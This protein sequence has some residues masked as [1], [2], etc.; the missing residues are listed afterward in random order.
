MWFGNIV[1]LGAILVSIPMAVVTFEALLAVVRGTSKQCD[2]GLD[3]FPSSVVLVPAHNEEEVIGRTL[4]SIAVDLP[5]NCRVLCVAHNCSD[6]T[7]EI[8]RR[9]GAEAIEVRDAGTG[10]KPDA[11][12]AGLSWLD[13]NPP[14]VVVIVDADCTVGQGTIRILATQASVLNRPVMGAYFF[15]SDAS[16]GI[17]TLSELAVMLKNF[18]RPLGLSIVG[19]PCLLNG[20]GSAYPF[21]LIRNAPHGEQSIAEDYQ[22]SVDL[23]RMGYPTTFVP[24]ARIDGQLPKQENTALRQRRRWEHGHLLLAFRSAPIL[25]LEGLVR[26]DKNRIGL[27]L[28]LSVPP[29]AFLGL[30]WGIVAGLSLVQFVIYQNGPLLLL[31]AIAVL[32]AVTVITSWIHFVGA[33][34][35]FSALVAAPRYL[36][37]KL[38]LYRDFFTRRETRWMKT[39]RD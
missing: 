22:L 29:L 16:A 34:A 39:G 28:E 13:A 11:L 8:A 26:L 31:L 2:A 33:R 14:E 15:A 27:A 21:H 20:S 10:G 5:P 7:A 3:P 35:T 12:K 25:L 18:I 4:E 24:W 9:N 1:W 6:A 32:L 37:W 19:L 23:L 36:L 38:P 17:A 30:M